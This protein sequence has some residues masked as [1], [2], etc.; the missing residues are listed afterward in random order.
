[1][2]SV[3]ILSHSFFNV[4][5]KIIPCR[6]AN[7]DLGL[8]DVD[9]GLVPN[10]AKCGTNKV[11]HPSPNCRHRR[12]D[13]S[14]AASQMCVN[15]TCVPVS[16]VVKAGC[17]QNC[18]Y[19]GECNNL[20]KCHCKVGFAPPFCDYPGPGGSL[21]G[22]PASDPSGT[23]SVAH[24]SHLPILMVLSLFF[25]FQVVRN[26]FVMAMFI[27]FLGIVPVV[28]LIFCWWYFCRDRRQRSQLWAKIQGGPKLSLPCVPFV[29][30]LW[31]KLSSILL[32]RN[33]R[34]KQ[35]KI[36]PIAAVQLPPAVETKEQ[37]LLKEP[38]LPCLQKADERLQTS[39]DP[40]RGAAEGTDKPSGS[41]SK[42]GKDIRIEVVTVQWEQ[43]E[44]RSK[45][46]SFGVASER[47]ITE[48][49]DI[50]PV[51]SPEVRSA[52]SSPKFS[53][54]FNE[55]M[56]EVRSW[57]KDRVHL[58]LPLLKRSASGGD[59]HSS[60]SPSPAEP[61]PESSS[62]FAPA[63]SRPPP[64]PPLAKSPANPPPPPPPPPPS[65]SKPRLI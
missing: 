60:A 50:S 52:N 1:M 51:S 62:P 5:G 44:P 15:Q 23:S 4:D 13:I 37:I 59:P 26:K 63:G 29:S 9:P 55:P 32:G 6:T 49:V 57:V 31:A 17:P 64:P 40:G 56:K 24:Q 45:L 25:I 28:A 36:L 61:Y 11:S 14:F 54:R 21:D 35:T 18:N 65:S 53:R 33:N 19:N 46:K 27:I 48:R 10:G 3:A 22:G 16:S 58:K 39:D 47:L 42:K 41:K 7:V 43:S 20:G 30:I 34:P 38:I 2:E 12:L 8:Q